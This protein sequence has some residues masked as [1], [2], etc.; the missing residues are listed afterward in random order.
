MM[1][2]RTHKA[3]GKTIRAHRIMET[4]RFAVHEVGLSGMLEFY[5][6]LGILTERNLSPPA[7]QKLMQFMHYTS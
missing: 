6:G 3:L 2:L 4:N 5:G 1:I 7:W